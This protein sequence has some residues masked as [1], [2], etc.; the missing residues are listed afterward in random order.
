MEKTKKYKRKPVERLYVIWTNMRYRCENSNMRDYK[1]YGGKG[2]KVC[3]EWQDYETFK[4]W[5]IKN[6]YEE[7]L[8]ID[9]IDVNGNYEPSNCRWATRKTQANNTTRNHYVTHN[10]VTKTISEWAEE[11][12]IS[13]RTI[14][15]RIQCGLTDE[16]AIFV[17]DR[18]KKVM[19]VI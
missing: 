17:N 10:G 9:R 14:Y 1:Y 13:Q 8:T 7:N 16:E 3:K 5:A 4:E 12:N 2:T 11:L 19:Q 15:Y 6:G 18:R